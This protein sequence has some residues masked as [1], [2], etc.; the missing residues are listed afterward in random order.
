MT[1]RKSTA[2]VHTLRIEEDR[3]SRRKDIVAVEEPLE[4][5]IGDESVAVT[6]RT[7]GND[8]ELAAGFLFTEG[9]LQRPADVRRISYCNAEPQEYNI[10]TV[11]LASEV[12]FDP[13]RLERHF[14]ATSACGVC[15]KAALETI[16]V[17]ARPMESAFTVP[18]ELL[19]SLDARL[20]QSQTVFDRTGS[21]HAAAVFDEAGEV[22]FL[23]EDVGRHNA[24]DKVVGAAFLARKVP[25]DRHVL[26]VS[27]RSSFEILQKAL[28]ARIPVVASVGG[29][30]SLAIDLAAEFGLTLVSFLRGRRCNVYAGGQRIV[31]GGKG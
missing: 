19:F 4:I 16:R 30:S 9:I 29:P 27:G 12:R 28:L 1:R 11:E 3:S 6:M 5:R 25:L 10:V 31:S 17:H 14:F 18:A 20:R 24:V 23:R 7:P 8:F 22:L 15:G 13:K 21:L 2:Q 26:M